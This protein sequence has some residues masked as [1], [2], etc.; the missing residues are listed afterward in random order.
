MTQGITHNSDALFEKKLLNIAKADGDFMT[1]IPAL[2]VHRRSHITD[3]IPCIYELGLAITISGRK[4]VTIGDEVLS[5][6]KG[7]SLLA[8]VDLPVVA[9]V[10]EASEAQPYLGIMLRLNPDQIINIAAQVDLPK[11]SR[12]TKPKGFAQGTLDDTLFSAVKRLVVLLDEPKLIKTVA[13]LIQ[14]EIIARLLVGQLGDSLLQLNANGTPHKQIA[15][16]IAWL[17][18]NYAKSFDIDS[19]AQQAHMSPTTFRQHFKV[20]TGMSPLQYVK[21]LRLQEAKQ[22]MLNQG[23]DVS[24]SG[25][26]VGYESIPQ[27]TREYTRL[28]GE[29]PSKNIKQLKAKLQEVR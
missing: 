24:T 25:L 8:S 26:R 23:L 15:T 13:P 12:K 16:V 20:V 6:G 27:F 9:E 22:L 4:Q 18:S 17:K 10:T 14:Q 11:T 28:F 3:P 19:L 29:S 5:Y 1:A 2:S 7:Q 21:Q